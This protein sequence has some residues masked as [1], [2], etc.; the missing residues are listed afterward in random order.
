[1]SAGFVFSGWRKDGEGGEDH[2]TAHPGLERPGDQEG[3]Q[4]VEE[5]P[6]SDGLLP[7]GMLPPKGTFRARQFLSL[8]PA[9][10]PV[11]TDLILCL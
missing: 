4:D 2:D 11:L 5:G 10:S 6:D 9:T 3:G 7:L 1:M 8:P